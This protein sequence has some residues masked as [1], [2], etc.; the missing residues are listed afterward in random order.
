MP[1][2][3]RVVVTGLGVVTPVG[4]GKDNFWEA[5]KAG[6]N[7]IGKITRFDATGYTVQIAGEVT[8]FDPVNFI[9]KKENLRLTTPNSTLK[10]STAT[11]QAYSSVRA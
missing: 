7:G 3:N 8:D 2:R 5:L 9:D 10:K 11:A 1:E 4:T 6:K